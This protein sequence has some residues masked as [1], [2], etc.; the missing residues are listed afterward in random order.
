MGGRYAEGSQHYLPS[1]TVAEA[2]CKQDDG[3]FQ[4]RHFSTLKRKNARLTIR[5]VSRTK[6]GH[7]NVDELLLSHRRH[8]AELFAN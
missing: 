3:G 7:D 6:D 8:A 4:Q 5:T 1:R 2:T